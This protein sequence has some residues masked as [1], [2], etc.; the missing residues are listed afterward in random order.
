MTETGTVTQLVKKWVEKEEESSDEGR[1]RW[2]GEREE[3]V[4]S[5]WSVYFEHIALLQ[6]FS[7][8]HRKREREKGKG[9]NSD[10]RM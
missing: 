6:M 4:D 9:R 2:R 8:T 10:R 7:S 5:C 1:E 3:L